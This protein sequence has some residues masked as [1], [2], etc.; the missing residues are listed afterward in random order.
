MPFYFR[1]QDCAKPQT[2]H[3]GTRLCVWSNARIRP[4]I[5]LD[6][7]PASGLNLQW[8]PETWQEL[9]YLKVPTGLKY[10]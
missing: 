4:D 3:W 7:F 8:L 6:K 9:V 1:W 2:L 10:I 5:E